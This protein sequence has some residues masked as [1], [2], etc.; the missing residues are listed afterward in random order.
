LVQ[1]LLK[2]CD[3]VSYAHARGIIHKDIKP[4]NIMVGEYGE[5]MVVD[6]GTAVVQGEPHEPDVAVGTPAYMAPEQ[7][8]GRIIDTRADVFALGATLFHALLLR[9]PLLSTDLETTIRRRMAGEF[10]APRTEEMAGHP[11]GLLAIAVR[12]LSFNPAD[13]YQTV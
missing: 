1:V 9:K 4:D 8:L 3:A 11:R 5:V 13:R 12:A 10:D 2:V 6:W 7:A